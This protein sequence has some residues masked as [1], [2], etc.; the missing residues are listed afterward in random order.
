MPGFSLRVWGADCHRWRS[1]LRALLAPCSVVWLPKVPGWAGGS[2]RR[3]SWPKATRA[4]ILALTN[5]RC[6]Y[7]GIELKSRAELDH[8]V[9]WDRGGTDT[10]DNLVAACH[11]CNYAKQTYSIREFR[12]YLHGMT[13]TLQRGVTYRNAARYGLIVE[14]VKPVVF[15]AEVIGLFEESP[16]TGHWIKLPPEPT[17]FDDDPEFVKSSA[18]TLAVGDGQEAW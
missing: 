6:A 9:A 14:T 2:V 4:A 12:A 8:I 5:G 3:K 18:K 10:E 13:R 7:C 15:Y 16:V 1:V 17:L 11:G